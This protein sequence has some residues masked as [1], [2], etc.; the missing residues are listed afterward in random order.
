LIDG[1]S[2]CRKIGRQII[3]RRK[4][5]HLELANVV[6]ELLLEDLPIVHLGLVQV[7]Q[8]EQHDRQRK[9][10][11][12]KALKLFNIVEKVF[13]NLRKAKHHTDHLEIVF[14]L[15]VL[16]GYLAAFLAL[17]Q[18]IVVHVEI[19]NDFHVWVATVRAH[20]VYLLFQ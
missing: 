9:A 18:A 19:S 17:L 15:N 2:V 11:D 12:F 10:F 20:I 8:E 1:Y 3:V 4:L 14:V 6:K 16:V 7:E 5:S 13:V